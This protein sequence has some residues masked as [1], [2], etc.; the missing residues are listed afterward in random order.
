ML[1][2]IN[3]PAYLPWLG[4]FHR[5]AISDMH[6]VLDHVQFEKNSYTNR[7]KIRI[8]Q[9]SSWLTVPVLTGG[10]FGDL[11]ISSLEIANQSW[12]RKHWETIRQNYTRTPFFGEHKDFLEETYRREWPRLADLTRFMTTY[13]L[14]ALDIKTPLLY[15]SEM[16]VE[17]AKDL[18]ILDICRKTGA[19]TYLSGALGRQ[20]LQVEPFDTAGVSI[21]YQDY[22]HP[23]YPQAY[24]GFEPYMAVIDLLL[25][26]GP[27]SLAIL[28]AGNKTAE[29]IRRSV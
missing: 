16:A 2:S 23:A 29:N 22:H 26:Q 3:Q 4:Y 18:L 17:G 20:Y 14:A 25:N 11:T 12:R 13:L 10:K 6:V 5:I 1:L 28:M 24:D 8:A 27:N 19:T 9:G 15:S 7:N 21:Y